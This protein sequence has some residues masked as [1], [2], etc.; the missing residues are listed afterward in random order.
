MVVEKILEKIE[1]L[2]SE[3]ERLQEVIDETPSSYTYVNVMT[4]QATISEFIEFL[5]SL[6][7][8]NN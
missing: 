2:Q 7:N 4:R 3:S 1:E 5:E 6:L 8:T